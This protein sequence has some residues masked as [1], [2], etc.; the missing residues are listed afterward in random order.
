MKEMLEA[1]MSSCKE[2]RT[3]LRRTGSK[4]I[5][6]STYKGD[7]LFWGTGLDFRNEKD[8]AEGNYQGRNMLGK[9]LEDVRNK[10]LAEDQYDSPEIEFAQLDED[11]VVYFERGNLPDFLTRKTLRSKG[12]NGPGGSGSRI[13][14]CALGG[15]TSERRASPQKSA[16]GRGPAAASSNTSIRP[17]YADMVN[18]RREAGRRRPL[19]EKPVIFSRGFI[20][21]NNVRCHYCRE[22]GHVAKDCRYGRPV[23]CYFCKNVGHKRKW[24]TNN[25]S[26]CI[27]GNVPT[28]VPPHYQDVRRVSQYAGGG[29]Q[30]L[31]SPGHAS[32][33]GGG[34]NLRNGMTA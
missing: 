31:R 13:V 20:E 11:V 17:S 32:V 14:D 21:R 28:G 6:H 29:N 1:K 3:A 24:C 2:F 16:L 33:N 12:S 23:K 22:P 7:G 5:V 30:G 26:G 10:L 25:V 34:R 27:P 15:S 18:R 8:A 4:P 19:L 9:L